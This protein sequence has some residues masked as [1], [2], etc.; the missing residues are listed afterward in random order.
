MLKERPADV[1]LVVNLVL[2][3][4]VWVAEPPEWA[5]GPVTCVRAAVE[6]LATV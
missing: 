6:V 2:G 1:D 3:G 4:Q 5:L